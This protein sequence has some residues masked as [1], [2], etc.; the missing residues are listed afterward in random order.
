MRAL[1]AHCGFETAVEY[2]SYDVQELND[3]FAIR[4]GLH[5]ALISSWRPLW[6]HNGSAA[7]CEA[8]CGT[9]V[10]L[11][12]VT[13]STSQSKQSPN[14]LKSPSKAIRNGIIIN[15]L[16]SPSLHILTIFTH[17]RYKRVNPPAKRLPIRARRR[18]RRLFPFLR[19]NQMKPF[20]T[21]NPPLYPAPSPLPAFPP[22]PQPLPAYR[23]SARADDAHQYM[24]YLPSPQAAR[25]ASH[26]LL[27]MLA[28]TAA[29]VS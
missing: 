10:I 23:H 3:E 7:M 17:P 11:D 8:L 9:Q 14:S 25:L 21:P 28:L 29:W 2:D 26:I 27:Y 16:A 20:L 19:Q 13:G 1:L 15:S 12:G 6:F 18:W 24:Y 4:A 22:Y 5:G